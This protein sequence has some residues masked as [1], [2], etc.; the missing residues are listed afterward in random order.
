MAEIT[1]AALA[2]ML[3]PRPPRLI[4]TEHGR[5]YPDVASP[6]RRA[7]NRLLLHRLAETAAREP[8]RGLLAT[9]PILAVSRR[10][11]ANG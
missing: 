1:L 10:Y 2:K 6:L 7:G 8:P 3:C 9:C 11:R 5:H 4:F